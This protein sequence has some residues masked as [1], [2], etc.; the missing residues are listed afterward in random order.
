MGSEIDGWGHEGEEAVVVSPRQ[1][2]GRAQ[3]RVRTVCGDQSRAGC[4][5]AVRG[6]TCR[7]PGWRSRHDV[8]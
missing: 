7:R 5:A 8:S 6:D 1:H 2:W 3:D 4:R